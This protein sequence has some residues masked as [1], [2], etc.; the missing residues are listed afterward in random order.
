MP[1]NVTGLCSLLALCCL[2]TAA[3]ADTV[4]QWT[5]VQGRQHFSDTPPATETGLVKQIE[6]ANHGPADPDNG[7]RNGEIERL[8][9][10]EQRSARLRQKA[11]SARQRNDRNLSAQRS[12]CRET[13]SHMNGTRDRTKR[14]EYSN[15]LRKNCW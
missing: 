11:A 6:S 3:L 7:L 12:A 5:D 4:W 1:Q 9:R 8:R 15:Y 10:M 13:R 14:K 2:G